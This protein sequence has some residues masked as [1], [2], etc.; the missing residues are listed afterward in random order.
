M[1][2]EPIFIEIMHFAVTE[3]K[4]KHL[5][6]KYD[7]AKDNMAHVGSKVTDPKENGD[8]ANCDTLKTRRRDLTPI[9]ITNLESTFKKILEK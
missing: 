4:S 2:L 7:A 5:P 1:K 6:K 9:L 8:A 3:N